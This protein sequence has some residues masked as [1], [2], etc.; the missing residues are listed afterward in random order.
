[1]NEKTILLVD[2]T[3]LFLH[4]EKTFLQRTGI[5][6][7]TAKNGQQALAIT[8]EHFP[9][10]VFLDLHMPIMDGEACCRALKSDPDL[11]SIHVVMV[12]TDG[13]PQDQ[14]RCRDAGCDEILLKPINRTEF[15]A[16]AQ[17]FLQLPTR[18]HRYEA[19][20]QVRYGNDA[21]NTLENY[22]IDISSGGLF[23]KTEEPLD[24]DE[25]L[26]LEFTL[27]NSKREIS[28]SAE[29]AWVNSPNNPTKSTLPPGMGIRFVDISLDD[30]NAIRDFIK[31]NDLEILS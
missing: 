10:I 12:T 14:K 25:N 5:N 24:I 26:C 29:V 8:R 7:L 17:K 6:I 1:M 4:L 21:I 16:T 3:E 13:R 30:L 27:E 19:N 22:S 9:D 11:A 31:N 23:I 18:S 15:L 20:I 28:C 2:D